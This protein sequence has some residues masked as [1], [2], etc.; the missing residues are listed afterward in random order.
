MDDTGPIRPP[1]LVLYV[2]AG[3]GYC[4]DVRHHARA[5]G[6]DLEERDAWRDP[7]HRRALLDARGRSTVPVLR[8]RSDD[9][10]D[11]WMPESRDIMRYLSKR[12]GKGDSDVPRTLASAVMSWVQ[13]RKDN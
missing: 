13:G 12:F 6:L 9:G 3:C 8:I 10:D 11:E 1:D 2:G 4:A 7:E 5:L